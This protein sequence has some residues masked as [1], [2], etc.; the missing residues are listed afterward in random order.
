MNFNL[1]KTAVIFCLFIL[2]PLFSL[3]AKQA[4][5][6]QKPFRCDA[7]TF[8]IIHE[9]GALEANLE[10]KAPSTK[11]EIGFGR[12]RR[13][14][15]LARFYNNRQQAVDKKYILLEEDDDPHQ[16]ITFS[17]EDARAGIY[18]LRYTT[19]GRRR[20]KIKLSTTP[21]VS[22]GIQP[23][24][25]RL[26]ATARDQFK[27]IFLYVPRDAGSF[28][29]RINNGSGRIFHPNSR[30]VLDFTEDDSPD[31]D[32]R[33]GGNVWRMEL[34]LI[35]ARK[36]WFRQKGDF[37]AILCPDQET[38]EKLRSGMSAA[39]DGTRFP[40]RFQVYMYEW[41]NAL[42]P[43]D[44]A[45]ESLPGVKEFEDV[46]TA[47]AEK[48]R[49]LFGHWGVFSYLPYLLT[50]QTLDN[51]MG[52]ASTSL[53]LAVAYS[54]DETFNPFYENGKVLTR[55]LLSEFD[56]YL[57]LRQNDTTSDGSGL[58]G[59]RDGVEGDRSAFAL[60]APSLENERL[61]KLWLQGARRHV[62]RYALHRSSVENQS[63]HVPVNLYAL[64]KGSGNEL[65]KQLAEDWIDDFLNEQLNP[66]L[67]T[68]YLMEGYGPD[69]TYQGITT[70]MLAWYFHWTGDEEVKEALDKIYT[71]FN[72]TVAPEPG[73]EIL[74]ASNFCHR[75]PGSWVE[76]QYGGGTLSM[77]AHLESAALWHQ[78]IEPQSDN[79]RQQAA[80][81]ILNDLER[82]WYSGNRKPR[83]EPSSYRFFTRYRFFPDEIIRDAALP[84]S[85]SGDF[86]RTF[87]NEFIAIR[88]PGYYALV[89][90][91]KPDPDVERI[92]Q[93]DTPLSVQR[94]TGGGLSMF[95]TPAFG[96]AVLSKN[97]HAYANH[98]IRADFG[99]DGE[100]VDWPDYYTLKHE[101]NEDS[102]TLITT[103][104]MT[105][106]PAKI[107]RK[108][109]FEQDR[110]IQDIQVEF[111]ENVRLR[112]LVEQIPI[113]VT[114][115]LE[116]RKGNLLI[117]SRV[118]GNWQ[119][120]IGGNEVE[121]LRLTNRTT[122]AEVNILL[123][124]PMPVRLAPVR[125]GV[126]EHRA[127]KQVRGQKLTSLEIW[128]GRRFEKGETVRLRYVLTSS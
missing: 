65:Y 127:A 56:R 2:S 109:T 33:N 90:V 70:S 27:E 77:A 6:F 45:I 7:M 5:R 14:A 23:R 20:V 103:S 28:N 94:R 36:S 66:P 8:Y 54:L 13:L 46:L 38:A 21:S 50:A 82:Y 44:I 125:K 120:G 99:A 126:E 26:T 97:W 115:K 30:K 12:R 112:R 119:Q 74:G 85:K 69:A 114:D 53:A 17:S 3:Q 100:M 11:V 35:P 67:Q 101:F 72:H 63:A 95:W 128:L 106:V 49:R 73:G 123:A 32:I 91:G 57:D 51:P 117:S 39:A 68:G 102:G 76:R 79:N 18:Q 4:S 86:I 40:H 98:M 55:L 29:P 31:I 10:I 92:R 48:N 75:T 64:Y 1:S 116:D 108:H 9:G 83:R 96:S 124:K 121:A 58:F 88:R 41:I 113:P 34:D 104:D 71:L 93:H 118:K 43:E 78:D 52:N 122:D 110:I 87:G 61:G 59:I 24:S 62:E 105:E 47:E 37:D 89:Y 25:A 84:V 19:I 42:E 80:G 16:T 15:V 60:A 111:N 22:F 107:T 81:H